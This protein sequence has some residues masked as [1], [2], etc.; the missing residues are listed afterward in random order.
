M[1]RLVGWYF[2]ALWVSWL[3]CSSTSELD[4]TQQHQATVAMETAQ[5]AIETAHEEMK[6]SIELIKDLRERSKEATAAELLTKQTKLSKYAS[7]VGKA[8]RAVQAAATIANFAFTFFMPSD[9]DVITSLINERFKEVNAKLD[10]LGEKLDE[11]ETSI[12]ANSALNNFLSTRITWENAIKNGGKKLKDI[13]RAMGTK[14][15]RIEQVKLAEEFV[16]Y[17]ENNNLDGNV[18]NMYRFA[19]LPEG[20][21]GHNLFDLFIDEYGCDITKL[22]ELTF[23]IKNIMISASQQTLTYHYFKGDA[24]RANQ[25]FQEV[26]GYFFKIRREFDNRVWEC[27]KDSVKNAEKK[28]NKILKEMKEK[29]QPHEIIVH[30][31]FDELKTQHSWYTWAVAAVKKDRPHFAELHWRGQAKFKLDSADPEYYVVYQDAQDPPSTCS[32][33]PQIGN[34]L[35]FKGCDGCNHNYIYADENILSHKTCSRHELVKMVPIEDLCEEATSLEPSYRSCISDL[36]RQINEWDFISSTVDHSVKN[37]HNCG[38]DKCQ[39]H[40]H[41][42][43]IPFTQTHQCICRPYFEGESCEVPTDFNDDIERM[44]A[45]LRRSFN[46]MNG[47]PTAVDVFFSV[48]SLSRNLDEVVK[49]IQDS[50]GYTNKIVQHS[51]VIYNIEDIVDLYA[52]LQT[53][54]VTFNQFGQDVNRYLQTI[55]TSFQLR[56]RLKKMILGQ[57]ILDSPG[58]DIYNSYKRDYFNDNGGAGCSAR[59]NEAVK[60]FRDKL[61]YLDQ[62]LG[63][64]LLL[65]KKWL[66]ETKGTTESLRAKY[67][68]EAMFIHNTFKGR[69]RIYSRYWKSYSC[70]NL[71]VDGA[72]INCKDELTF[73]GMTLTVKCDKQRQATNGTVTCKKN[74]DILKWDSQPRCIFVWNTWGSWSECSKTCDTGT[75]R[76]ERSCMG[77]NNTNDCTRDQGGVDHETESCNTQKC[78]SAQYDKFDC[79]NSKCISVSWKCD[80]DNDCGNSHDENKAQCPHYIRSGDIVALKATKKS[81]LWL[82]C[83][84]ICRLTN[85]P[86]YNQDLSSSVWNSCNDNLFRVYLIDHQDEKP[87]KYGDQIRLE[88]LGLNRHVNCWGS[89]NGCELR[90]TCSGNSWWD[91]NMNCRGAVFWIYSTDSSRHGR[92]CSS[93]TQTNCRGKPLQQGDEVYLRYSINGNVAWWLSHYGDG[94]TTQTCPGLEITT[95]ESDGCSSESWTIFHK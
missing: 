62:A 78:C 56:N 88:R 19:A 30:A 84:G 50:K 10:R 34:L 90:D 41:C 23:F 12:K 51:Q 13:R 9:L 69:Q 43:V 92:H 14:T 45:D 54:D 83:W 85:C 75:R 20:I 44:L 89:G 63:E 94:I 72:N 87:V 79:S 93:N 47:V 65:H 22:S 35:V 5:Q 58:K 28:A 8:L 91:H 46:I 82:G 18:L 25:G 76:R 29:N 11:M 80:G 64:A 6:T 26:M 2:A 86:G 7:M 40:G 48:R 16:N 27:K 77:T 70:G 74:G 61:A 66:M 17:Y 38:S 24:Q 52:K 59:Y 67:K 68:K 1:R 3:S 33:I 81:A 71:T 55:T 95:H 21:T 15:R 73:E 39:R 53:N 57:G 49:K 31:I 60:S 36:K 4:P 42:A 32:S 37:K